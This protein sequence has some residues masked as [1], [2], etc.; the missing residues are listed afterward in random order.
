MIELNGKYTNAK[1][2]ADIIEDL[3]MDQIQNVIDT[4]ISENCQ[5][6]IMPDVHAGKGCTIG[7]TMTVHDKIVPNLV[8][9]DGSCGMIV[10]KLNEKSIDFEKL[11]GVIRKYIPYGYNINNT[12]NE[13]VTESDYNKLSKLHCIDDVDIDREILALG[14]LGSGNHFIELDVDSSGN[15]Y[16]IVH[17]GSRHLGQVVCK[18]YQK[19]AENNVRHNVYNRQKIIDNLKSQG[20]FSEIQSALES[21]NSINIPTGLE[22]IEGTD[23][24]NY[25]DDMKIINWYAG[26]NRELIV[27]T[28][29]K[30]M[31][32]VICKKLRFE[33]VHNFVEIGS[34]IIIR[35]GATPAYA[36]QPVLIPLN[37]RDGCLLCVG[38]GNRDW[39][40]SAPHG[41]GRLISRKKASETIS[42]EMY[43]DSM[44][45]VY[46]TCLNE[47]T[48]D[49]SPM[50]YKPI[51]SII[52]NISDT[53]DIVDHLKSVYNFKADS[54]YPLT[55]NQKSV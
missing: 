41:A 9:G 21:L 37:M 51:N 53:V 15:Y 40:Y 12:S 28:I 10:Q 39:N 47:N 5:V 8:G 33:S 31:N 30:H 4:N 35:K 11:D 42:M 55:N 50:A 46:T 48:L 16:L 6:C 32:W 45:N 3:A 1:I 34:N 14:S 18:H 2:Y 54:Q 38:K 22:Y 43:K 52:D 29:C 13:F 27:D 44:S 49:E 20:R 26:R 24:Q 36:G 19:I 25:L 23:L 17:T 7:F